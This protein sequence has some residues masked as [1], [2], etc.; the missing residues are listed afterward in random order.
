MQPYRTN[1]LEVTKFCATTTLLKLFWTAQQLEGAKFLKL[2]KS[3]TPGFPNTILLG[4][5]LRFPMVH[6]TTPNG[7]WLTSYGYQKMAGLLNSGKSGQI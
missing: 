5:S 3:E 2:R 6:F 1:G 4:N 7:Q